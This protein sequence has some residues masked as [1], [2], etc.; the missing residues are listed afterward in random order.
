[1]KR[2]GLVLFLAT[3]MATPAMAITELGKLWKEHYV[4]DK[5]P[6]AFATA[7]KK[8]NCNV[9]HVKGKDK[10]EVNNEYGNAL[11]E[12][13]DAE[14]VKKRLKTE[15]E[16]VKEEVTALFK[17]IEASKSKDG[18]AFGDKIKAGE[19]PATDAEI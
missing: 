15:P 13:V 9:C 10:K 4:T 2:F 18:K 16:K 3:V 17:K 8:A 6:E 1:M 14:D 12:L 5:S 11:K 19:L 7:V